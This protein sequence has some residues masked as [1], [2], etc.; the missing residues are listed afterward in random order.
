MKGQLHDILVVSR[1]FEDKRMNLFTQEIRKNPEGLAFNQELDL[2]KDL[3]KRNPEILD[4][5]N[6]TA[7]GG[8]AYDTGLYVL[9]YQLSYTIVLASSRSMEPVE[10]QESYP[11][12]EVFAE[13]V[14]S[15]ADIEAL[16]EDLILPIEG[17]KIDLSE[18][19]ADNILL[20]I[21]LKVLTPE[22]EAGQG[23]IEGNDWKIMTEEE[24]QEA[25]A[26]KK[27]ENSPFAGLQ[28]LFDGE[29]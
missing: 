28:G 23:F 10:I 18:S 9:D 21:P 7:T 19:V 26:L 16:E 6:V 20:N 8:V 1:R 14:Q 29:E 25:Q 22:E 11:V 4:L 5:K 15:E 13:D 24:Y 12:T 2:L 3:Q 17:G 27:E